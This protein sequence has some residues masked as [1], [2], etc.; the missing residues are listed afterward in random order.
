[1]PD[2]LSEAI[3]HQKTPSTGELCRPAGPVERGDAEA[4]GAGLEDMSTAGLVRPCLAGLV[5]SY[6]DPLHALPVQPIGSHNVTH[7]IGYQG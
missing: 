2:V 5:Y 1:M 3:I 7:N 4:L 6:P